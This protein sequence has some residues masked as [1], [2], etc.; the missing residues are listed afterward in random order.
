MFR[1][2]NLIKNLKINLWKFGRIVS[3]NLKIG[4]DLHENSSYLEEKT[5]SLK[6]FSSSFSVVASA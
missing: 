4:Q 2:E 1:L 3:R 5:M 6:D